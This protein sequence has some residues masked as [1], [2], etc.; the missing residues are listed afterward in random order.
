MSDWN[1]SGRDFGRERGEPD[2]QEPWRDR[3]PV[4]TPREFE[5]RRRAFGGGFGLAGL[6]DGWVAPET[7]GFTRESFGGPDLMPQAPGGWESR[8]EG[9]HRGRGPRTYVRSDARIRED[10]SDR[11]CEDPWLDASEIEVQVSDAEVVLSGAVWSREDRRRAETLAERVSGVRHVQNNLRVEPAA[12]R[13]PAG[14]PSVT[15]GSVPP[16]I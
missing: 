14:F 2:A 10:V 13:E 5:Q 15:G 3:Y 1:R 6:E 16:I 9:P 11:L 4:E 12:D 7:G 8:G